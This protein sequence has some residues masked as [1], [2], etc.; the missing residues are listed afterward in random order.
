MEA[1]VMAHT[2]TIY[3]TQS[4]GYCPGVINHINRKYGGRRG[5]SV[6]VIDV[7][8]CKTEKCEQIMY[9]PYVELDGRQVEVSQLEQIL[10]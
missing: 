3:K 2:I 7:D 9:T 5:V 1:Q 10:R 6:E 8:Q 4:C